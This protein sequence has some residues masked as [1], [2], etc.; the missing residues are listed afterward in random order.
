MRKADVRYNYSGIEMLALPRRERNYDARIAHPSQRSLFGLLINEGYNNLP[1]GKGRK[2]LVRQWCDPSTSIIGTWSESSIELLK[3]AG[4]NE[5][6]PI[7]LSDVE[8]QLMRWKATMT[9]PATNS[10]WA[11]AKPHECFVSGTICFRHPAYDSQNHIYSSEHM[12]KYTVDGIPLDQFLTPRTKQGLRDRLEMLTNDELYIAA[13][14]AQA[15]YV[16]D[17][18][19]RLDGGYAKVHEVLHGA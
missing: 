5:P 2:D 1:E 18:W 7:A 8:M 6:R 17:A 14:H 11:T 4:F 16:A 3:D 15:L 12:G 13:A 10:G 9:F 19:R